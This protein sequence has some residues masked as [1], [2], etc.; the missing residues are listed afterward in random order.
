M[1]NRWVTQ[2]VLGGERWEGTGCNFFFKRGKEGCRQSRVGEQL[3]E[4]VTK[5]Q[6][7]RLAR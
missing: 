4:R 6:V 3:G 5:T 2:R 1:G 7:A